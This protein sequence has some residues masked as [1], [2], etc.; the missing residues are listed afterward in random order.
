MTAR[1]RVAIVREVDPLVHLGE[2]RL[3]NE[4]TREEG[5]E[6]FGLA[7]AAAGEHAFGYRAAVVD[8]L[9][10]QLVRRLVGGQRRQAKDPVVDRNRARHLELGGDDS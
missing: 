10:A 5:L 3:P 4:V 8:R 9:V 7:A 1:R 2:R 6:R